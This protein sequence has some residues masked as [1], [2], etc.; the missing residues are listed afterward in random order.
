MKRR[1]FIALIS[2]AAIASVSNARTQPSSNPVV[3]FVH[4]RSRDVTL[5]LVAAFQR[6]LAESGLIV[7]QNL[8]VDYRFADGDYARLPAIISELVSRPVNVLVTGADP[9]AIAGKKAAGS[10]PMVFV[11]AGDPVA[12]GLVS[13]LNRPSGNATGMTILTTSLEPKRIGLFREILSPNITVGALFNPSLPLSQKQA[14]AVQEAARTINLKVQNFWAS[15][16]A[17]L[18]GAFD[19]LLDQHIGALLVAAD[20][21]FDSRRDTFTGWAAQ[22]KIPSMFQF[23]DYAVAGGLMSYG[24][25]L[26]DVYRQIG[27]YTARIL[28]GEKPSDLPVTEPTKF[29]LVINLKTVKAL[30]LTLPSGLMSIADEVIE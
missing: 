30:G 26:P 19:S 6:G 21:F 1:D 14:Q 15:N 7:G 5:P 9:V 22:H 27:G 20:P 25:D 3:G 17:E 18:A 2:G 12:L 23:R 4:A 13:S 16:D 11:V 8:A 28:K 24:I 29:E 10:I